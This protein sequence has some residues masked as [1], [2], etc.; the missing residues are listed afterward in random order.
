[1][2]GWYDLRW[3]GEGRRLQGELLRRQRDLRPGEPANIQFTSGVCAGLPSFIDSIDVVA[4]HVALQLTHRLRCP[5]ASAALAVLPSLLPQLLQAPLAF[6]KP[7]PCRTMASSTTDCWWAP[8]AA[9]QKQ[10]GKAA[11]GRAG[12]GRCSWAV[13][14]IDCCCHTISAL[15]RWPSVPGRPSVLCLWTAAPLAPPAVLSMNPSRAGCASL[16]RCSIA[17]AP[18]WAT[19]RAQRMEPLLSTHQV[20]HWQPSGWE[21]GRTPLPD[22]QTPTMHRHPPLPRRL[23]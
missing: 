5:P 1:M 2:V 11:A 15:A 19:L 8:P 13:C 20:W 18:S 17:L 7:P 3:A 4:P 12:R 14:A 16:C 23:L 21:A 22:P 10:T 6:P 9:T